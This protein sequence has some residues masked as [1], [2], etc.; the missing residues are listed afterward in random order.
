MPA[1][2]KFNGM[3]LI[4]NRPNAKFCLAKAMYPS[5]FVA[6]TDGSLPREI[7]EIVVITLGDGSAA[8][9]DGGSNKKTM[10]PL[11]D[12]TGDRRFEVDI[13]FYSDID[14]DRLMVESIT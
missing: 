14:S 12:V 13:P 11:A 7:F 6:I 9:A 4:G 2:V 10:I 8:A 5:D 1:F 3:L